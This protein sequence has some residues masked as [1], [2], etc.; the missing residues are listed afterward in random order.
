MKKKIPSFISQIIT[1]FQE[2]NFEIYLVGGAVRDFLLGRPIHDW[3]FTTNASPPQIQ[4]LF[5]KNSFYNNQFGTVTVVLKDKNKKQTLVEITTFR[6]E[7]KYKDSRHPEKIVWGKSLEEDLSRRDFTINAMAAEVEIKK[8]QAVKISR[9]IDPFGGKKD[10]KK[11]LIRAVGDPQKRFQEDA[12]RMIRAIRIASQLG[13]TIEEKTFA[14]IKQNASLIKKIAWER[15]RDELFRLLVSP[16]CAQGI[17]F[18][19]NAGLLKYIMPELIAARG[20]AQAKHHVDDVWTHSLKSL[21]FCPSKDPVVR[22][23][24]LLHDIGKPA[25]ARGE[26]ENRTFY[27][28]EVVGAKIART[29]GQRLKLSKKDQERLYLLVRHHQFS[30]DENQTDKA[31]RRFIRRVG[32]ENLKDI[33][34]VRTGDRL[35]GGAKKT[36]WRLELFK[37][38][39]AEV[40]KQPFSLK[41]LKVNGH[42]VMK[43]LNIP[44][45]PAVGKILNALFALVEEDKEK[46]N[47][48]WLLKQIPLVAKKIINENNAAKQSKGGQR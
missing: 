3:D 4:K 13:F 16:F 26:G 14:A 17:L 1:P 22:L 43:V 38:R 46:N 36:S 5:P 42:D 44:P 11:R 19:Y 6:K 35:G 27:N 45:G 18:L 15:I 47:R 30:V 10:L 40:Q 39:L 21:Q 28:H 9:I 25:T 41:D 48:R 33:L 24:T 23:A 8:N 7:G 20:V 31:I 32:K 34:D 29:I 12:L 37:K 2:N